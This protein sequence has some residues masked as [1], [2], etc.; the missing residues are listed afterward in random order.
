[1]LQDLAV[2]C[3]TDSL[4]SVLPCLLCGAFFFSQTQH[5]DTE[6]TARLSDPTKKLIHEI[7]RNEFVL[8]DVVTGSIL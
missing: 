7:T 6:I 1:M 4:V 2:K 5:G 8:F 3:H